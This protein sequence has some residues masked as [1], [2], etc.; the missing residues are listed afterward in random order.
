MHRL[1]RARHLAFAM[2]AWFLLSLG[3]AG[4]APAMAGSYLPDEVCSVDAGQR[5][6]GQDP[7][8]PVDPV[9]HCPACVHTAAPPPAD[10]VA[11]VH[12]HAPAI[13]TVIAVRQ[14]PPQPPVGAWSARGP[15]SL[16]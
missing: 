1:R 4:L 12:V 9:V 5:S 3:V 6:D 7:G 13:A 15:P 8:A 14:L 11:A 10:P 16:S 2:L